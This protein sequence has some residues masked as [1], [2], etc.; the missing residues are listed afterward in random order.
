MADPFAMAFFCCD[1][2]FFT[3]YDILLAITREIIYNVCVN[4]FIQIRSNYEKS[5]HY[6]GF[7][8]RHHA[9]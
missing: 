6:H 4:A 2:P 1:F 3:R 9:G 7:Q 8:L 5:S